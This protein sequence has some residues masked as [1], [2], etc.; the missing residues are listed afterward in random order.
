MFGFYREWITSIPSLYSSAQSHVL[1]AGNYGPLVYITRSVRQGCPLAP[2][3][4]LFFVVAMIS[5]LNIDDIGLCGLCIP[6]SNVEFKE[7][8]F[9]NDNALYLHGD[10]HNLRKIEMT[11]RL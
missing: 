11:P 9:S 8:E 4:F 10:L 1:L 7:V 2:F 3:L 6:F 5:F